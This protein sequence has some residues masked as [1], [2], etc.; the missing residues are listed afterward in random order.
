M[1]FVTVLVRAVEV[2][3]AASEAVAETGTEPSGSAEASMPDSVTVPAPC[4]AGAVADVRRRRP[5]A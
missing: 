3:P 2:L 1:S 5:R 4:V